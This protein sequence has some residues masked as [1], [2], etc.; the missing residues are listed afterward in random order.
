MS[1]IKRYFATRVEGSEIVVDG[2][3]SREGL[4]SPAIYVESVDD[5]FLELRVAAASAEADLLFGELSELALHVNE[6]AG[7]GWREV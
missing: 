7:S 2:V 4:G 6:P 1:C 5:R 3:G